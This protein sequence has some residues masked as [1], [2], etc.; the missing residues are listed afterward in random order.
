MLYIY[1]YSKYD[2]GIKIIRKQC[3]AVQL[4]QYFI[5]RYSFV[6]FWLLF[7]VQYSIQCVAT[8]DLFC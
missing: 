6:L 5:R 1:I 7:S 4:E 3:P 8:E 2:F